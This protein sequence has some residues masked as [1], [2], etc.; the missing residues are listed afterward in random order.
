MKIAFGLSK[1]LADSRKG[2]LDGLGVYSRELYRAFRASA[3]VERLYPF[4]FGTKCGEDGEDICKS[5]L[6]F[7]LHALLHYALKLPFDDIGDC[8]ARADIVFAPDHHIPYVGKKPVV[9]TVMDIIPIIEPAWASPGLLRPVKNGLFAESIRGAE[10]IITVS[11][12]SKRDIVEYIGVAGERISVVPLGVDER[13]RG[14][15]PEEEIEALLRRYRI[16]RG[17]FLFVGTIQPRKNLRRALEAFS[18]LPEDIRRAHPFVVAGQYGWS[19]R[20]DMAL[21]LELQAKG[22][23][24]WL[25]YVGDDELPILMRCAEALVYPSLYEGFGLPVI[26]AFAASC[27]VIASHSSSIPEVA[28]EAALYIDPLSPSSIAAAMQKI[29]GD[30]SLAGSLAK[31]GRERAQRYSW[32]KAASAH[33]EAISAIDGLY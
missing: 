9:A 27:P 19:A 6:S 7:E 23:A 17:F 22:C 25:D 18:S 1:L 13:F 14:E 28:A 32:Q 10:R 4:C 2:R 12:H 29:A 11:Q 31:K 33:I 15:Y 8:V 20:E 3:E 24:K 30:D 26:E 5:P 21:L 16:G